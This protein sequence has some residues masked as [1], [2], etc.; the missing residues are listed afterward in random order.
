[1]YILLVED[2]EKLLQ[3]LADHLKEETHVVDTATDGTR[4][5]ELASQFTYDLIILD[6]ML[7]GMNG[8][9]LLSKIRER[10][11]DVPILML[12]AMDSVQDKVQNFQAGA[13]DYLT[14]PFSFDELMVRVRSLLRRR[15]KNQKDSIRLHDLEIDRLTHKVKRGD[16]RIDLSAKEY[17]LLE[18]LALNPGRVLSRAMIIDHVWGQSF[19]NLTNI[20]DVYIRQLR[21][22]LDDNSQQKLIRTVRGSGYVF[23][24]E[25]VP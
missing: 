7:P 9:E 12:T 11:T 16:Q 13:D 19:E 8:T 1:M 14:K 22:K 23:G 25:S 24:E 15:Q 2:E 18:Y 5:Y 20:V 3:T 4:G 6:I 21:S 17:A 10:D